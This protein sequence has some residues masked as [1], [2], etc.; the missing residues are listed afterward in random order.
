MTAVVHLDGNSLT[1]AHVVAIADGAAIALDAGQL[2][3]VQRTA[4][5]LAAQLQI[6]SGMSVLD[7]PC[8]NGRHAVELARC[9][10]HMTG[11]D[12]SAGFVAEARARVPEI[13]W[14][15]GD[16]RELPWKS[17]FDA[18]YCWGNSFAYFDH[19]NCC[20]FLEAV[21]R[22]LKAGGRQLSVRISCD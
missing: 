20:R 6:E 22:A 21:A 9:G 8:G 10:I 3:K 7:V 5:F 19:D 16:M 2:Q 1:R 14:V 13:E 4:D 18:A 12:L 11:V 17:R 15:Q